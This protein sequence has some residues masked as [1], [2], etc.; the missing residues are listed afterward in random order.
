[1][2]PLRK[3]WLEIAPGIPSEPPDDFDYRHL[4]EPP[5]RGR[6]PFVWLLDEVGIDAKYMEKYGDSRPATYWQEGLARV[7]A[8]ANE[9]GVRL[10][11][12]YSELM[13]RSDI[14]DRL[15]SPTADSFGIPK[16][17]IVAIPDREGEYLLRFYSDSQSCWHWYIYWDVHG[18]TCVVGTPFDF[19]AGYSYAKYNETAELDG[20]NPVGGAWDALEEYDDDLENFLFRLWVGQEAWFRQTRHNRDTSNLPPSAS[21]YLEGCRG[22]GKKA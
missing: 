10:P 18:R 12:G 1:M 6:Q 17:G 13:R 11:D 16:V 15:R 8:Q 5:I 4:P 3:T 7:E 19:T 2:K 14:R 9:M 21:M 22:I 20:N